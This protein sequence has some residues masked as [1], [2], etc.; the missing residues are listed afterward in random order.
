MRI[1]SLLV[2]CVCSTLIS[3]TTTSKT[4]QTSIKTQTT[5]QTIIPLQ[6]KK[7]DPI[8]VSFYSSQKNFNSPYKVIGEAIVSKY[9]LRGIKRQN[10]TIHEAMRTLA[11]SMGGDAVIEVKHTEMAVIG[12]VI[13]YQ[14]KTVA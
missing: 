5:S 3:C 8:E 13:A 14:G 12:K 2:V 11:A 7:K 6:K 4:H 1:S 9:N 10:A